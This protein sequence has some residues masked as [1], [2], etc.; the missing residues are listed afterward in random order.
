MSPTLTY[1]VLYR[2]D[3]GV[4]HLVGI[5]CSIE[6]AWDVVRADPYILG[7]DIRFCEMPSG[8][9]PPDEEIVI[10]NMGGDE[11]YIALL[12]GMAA[13]DAYCAAFASDIPDPATC[14]A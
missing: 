11:H 8:V 3:N 1:C 4:P 14:C 9:P 2:G 13:F 6:A 7:S 10:A 5:V 12:G